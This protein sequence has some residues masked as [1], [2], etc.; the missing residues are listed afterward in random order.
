MLAS[1]TCVNAASLALREG[2]RSSA[3]K[4]CTCSEILYAWKW[5]CS[6]P[7]AGF[8]V[9]FGT[10]GPFLQGS[11]LVLKSCETLNFS[12]VTQGLKTIIFYW[13]WALGS[14]SLTYQQCFLGLSN[15][16]PAWRSAGCCARARLKKECCRNRIPAAV[17]CLPPWRKHFLLPLVALI[18]A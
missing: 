14:L 7:E 6:V 8:F 13:C 16:K 2:S 12:F 17:W 9:P 18:S 10:V 15:V 11:I 3:V 4:G 5:W 1:T